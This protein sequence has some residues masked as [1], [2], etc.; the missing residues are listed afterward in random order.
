[1]ATGLPYELLIEGVLHSRV[2]D[3][4]A[5]VPPEG[6]WVLQP[7]AH[8]GAPE[9]CSLVVHDA[10]AHGL[11]RLS[12]VGLCD[13]S[14]LPLGA[15]PPLDVLRIEAPLLG[16][17]GLE[18]LADQ[19]GLQALALLD[20][21]VE[22]LTPLRELRGLRHLE[23]RQCPLRP[24]A[25]EALSRLTEL[26]RLSL[27]RLGL[28]AVDLAP[29][30]GL[31][32]LEQLSLEGCHP[33]PAGLSFL[34]RLR[35]LRTL[36]LSGGLSL[37]DEGLAPLATLEALEALSLA[38]RGGIR[39]EGLS[40]LAGLQSL[41]RLD[42][43]GTSLI[44]EHLRHLSGLR[45]LE[46]LSLA[47]TPL[48][49]ID[50]LHQH[51]MEVNDPAAHMLLDEAWPTR[52]TFRWEEG[53]GEAFEVDDADESGPIEAFS[54]EDLV[55]VE[56]PRSPGER[57]QQ[58]L[59][60][61]DTFDIPL[62]G[63][64][65]ALTGLRHLTALVELRQLDLQGTPTRGEDLTGLSWPWLQQLN[66]GET[67]VTHL[68]RLGPLPAL[69]ALDLTGVLPTPS[70]I[71]SLS[72]LS[73]LQ[74]LRLSR[75]RHVADVLA[76][77]SALTALRSL[78]LHKSEL[79][80]GALAPLAQLPALERLS[81]HGARLIDAG[82]ERLA[83]ARALTAL[84]LSRCRFADEDLAAVPSLGGVRHL[85][86]TRTPVQDAHVLP[87]ASSTALRWLGLAF[88]EVSRDATRALAEALPRATV[89]RSF[90]PEDE[91]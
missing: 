43:S 47:R 40:A 26:E 45:A 52:T 60:S 39:G 53:H 64:A 36:D 72:S 22:R 15:L 34:R 12:L 2:E 65:P 59:V 58:L 75:G 50:A 86:L 33:G 63:F 88:T 37:A 55:E 69:L 83:E 30:A 23:V 32:A 54:A 9:I 4:G 10:R 67:C 89:T 41:R 17:E 51:L 56:E 20:T 46:W 70:L 14:A 66:L 91:A 61:A 7:A 81:L 27:D 31:T 73:S 76:P 78:T 42:L 62:D 3:L 84:D 44:H 90:L 85:D 11:T 25:T 82:L 6:D 49:D 8:L 19:Q 71:R 80:D 16:D 21:S 24:G 5:F 74:G 79:V 48:W 13:D 77:L 57:V 28:S 87:L 18:A 38:G 68:D 29:L 35:R 1:M